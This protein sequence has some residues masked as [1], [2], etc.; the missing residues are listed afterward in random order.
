M[1]L[2][3]KKMMELPEILDAVICKRL[4]CTMEELEVFTEIGI[5]EDVEWVSEMS[6]KGI[7]LEKCKKILR[8]TIRYNK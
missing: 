6:L 3:D 2:A 7:E 5:P 1:D 4:D 8:S